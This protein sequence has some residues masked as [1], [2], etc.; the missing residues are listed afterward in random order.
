MRVLGI[1][2]DAKQFKWILVQGGQE[3][4]ERLE[5]SQRMFCFQVAMEGFGPRSRILVL[6]HE[7]LTEAPPLRRHAIARFMFRLRVGPPQANTVRYPTNT[8]WE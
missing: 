8:K 5:L 6:L 2:P 4:P 3:S 7:S 1:A